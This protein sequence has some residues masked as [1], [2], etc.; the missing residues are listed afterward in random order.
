MQT[1]TATKRCLKN[2]YSEK[3]CIVQIKS[4][5]LFS[6]QVERLDFTRIKFVA[7]FHFSLF[8]NFPHQ[9]TNRKT[10]SVAKVLIFRCRPMSLIVFKECLCN[11][12]TVVVDLNWPLFLK[13]KEDNISHSDI[14]I[15]FT[16]FFFWYTFRII[17][18][19]DFLKNKIL[20][21]CYDAFFHELFIKW[22]I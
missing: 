18:H 15:T 2:S 19:S 11:T 1:N 12:H 3:F 21:A 4:T 5:D 20:A 6:D 17:L 7:N 10:V 16:A 9:K 8:R 22:R 14:H 13:F